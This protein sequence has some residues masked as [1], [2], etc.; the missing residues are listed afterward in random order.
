MTLFYLHL[1]PMCV[2][3]MF[4]LI[5]LHFPAVQKRQNSFICISF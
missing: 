2:T 4:F 5:F 1:E 3:A